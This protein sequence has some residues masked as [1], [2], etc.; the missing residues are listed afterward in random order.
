MNRRGFTLIELLA[1]IVVLGLV[2]IIAIPS[3]TDAYKNSKIKSEEV[4]VDRLSE[5]IDSY[6]KLNSD[7]IE[8]SGSG[9][10]KKQENGKDYPIT[11]QKGTITISDIIEDGILT[12]KDFINAGNKEKTCDTAAEVEV[13]KDSDFVYCYKV[14]VKEK[15]EEKNLDCLTDTYKKK[16]NDGYAINTC[17]WTEGE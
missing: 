1:V 3:V 14:K 2:L 5:A 8:F 12:E 10:G 4:F 16:L 7:E 15:E 6:V 9:T 13:Y 17:T 11:Y